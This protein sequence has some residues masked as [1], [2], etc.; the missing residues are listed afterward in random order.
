MGFNL[1]K[2]VVKGIR[3]R[4]AERAAERK[5][6]EAEYKKTYQANREKA[7]RAKARKKAMEKAKGGGGIMGALTSGAKTFQ[8]VSQKVGPSLDRE[9][10]FQSEG[11]GLGADPFGPPRRKK[12]RR[13]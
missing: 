8:S 12:R 7:L 6:Y 13:R 2:R 11:F 10:K 5:I 9:L 3:E 4:R 1:K